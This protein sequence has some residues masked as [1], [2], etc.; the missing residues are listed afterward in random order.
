[1]FAV[2]II[3]ELCEIARNNLA[4]VGARNVQVLLGDGSLGWP[5]DAPYDAIVVA[6]A[7]PEVPPPLCDQ[8]APGGRLL[9][10]VGEQYG[11]TLMRVH[12]RADGS[13]EV[14]AALRPYMGGLE[15]IERAAGG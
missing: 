3:P 9:V 2:E 1:M 6:A 15:A 13:I 5:H 14:P 4:A 11:Q 12:K 8:L 10:P 7:A